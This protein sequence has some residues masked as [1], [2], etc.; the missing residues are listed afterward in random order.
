MGKTEEFMTENDVEETK[1]GFNAEPMIF[2]LIFAA[3]S[4]I[5]FIISTVK[6]GKYSFFVFCALYSMYAAVADSFNT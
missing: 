6:W 2:V 4:I 1:A 5:P 3:I